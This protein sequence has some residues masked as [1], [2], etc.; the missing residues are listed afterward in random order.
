MYKYIFESLGTLLL[1]FTIGMAVIEPGLGICAPLAIG[2]VLTLMIYAGVRIS[3]AH[4]NSAVTISLCL[5]GRFNKHYLLGYIAT[6]CISGVAAVVIV[7]LI[8]DNP[9]ALK[10]VQSNLL[11]I[12]FAEL[13]FTFALCLVILYVAT[14]SKTRDNFYYG[15]A[16]VLTV[17]V[18]AYAVGSRFLQ[19]HSIRLLRWEW[20]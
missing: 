7:G 6:Q 10:V 8:K 20:Q 1:V 11:H 5:R 12:F 2:L 13:I 15:V 19:V 17:V 4:Y 16:I 14:S 18:G 3:G 9:V